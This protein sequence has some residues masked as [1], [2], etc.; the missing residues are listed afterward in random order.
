MLQDTRA[1]ANLMAST[2]QSAV[3]AVTR[4]ITTLPENYGTNMGDWNLQD[5]KI[6]DCTNTVSLH[7]AWNIS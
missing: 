7:A 3:F 1:P 5:W 4:F 6:S 2:K